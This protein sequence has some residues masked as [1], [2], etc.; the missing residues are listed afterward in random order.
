MQFSN[1]SRAITTR[2]KPFDQ[3]V[4][5]DKKK[6]I[7]YID[8]WVESI[9]TYYNKY[10]MIP[11]LSI[12]LY[13]DPGTG[14]STFYRA[15]AKHLGISTVKVLTQEYFYGVM[16]NPSEDRYG[17]YYGYRNE[18][19][20]Y[21]ID[22]IDC[23]CESRNSKNNT[24]DNA[25]TLSNLLAFLDNPPTFDIKANDGIMYPV[26]IVV[27]TTNYFDKLD[28][29]VR[30]YGRFDLSLE[31]KNFD[32]KSAQKMCDIYDLKLEDLVKGSN[33]KN[34]QIT[35]AKLQALCLENIDNSLKKKKNKMESPFEHVDGRILIHRKESY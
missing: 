7:E 24:R 25:S 34:F 4:F 5:N 16:R 13:G 8:N 6:V 14:K 23:V 17:G 20:I 29:A 19:I 32:K 31:M 33:K 2:F 27:A 28:Y 18:P 9:P 3:L 12:L 11:K 35:P 26:S 1:G 10:K 22:D 30:R 21:A 15:L